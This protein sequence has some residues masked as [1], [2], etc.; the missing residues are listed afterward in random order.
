[1]LNLIKQIYAMKYLPVVS[2][3][4][5]LNE[6][7]WRFHRDL[8]VDFTSLYCTLLYIRPELSSNE[9]GKAFWSKITDS[10]AL[11]PGVLTGVEF[12]S[13]GRN[14]RVSGVGGRGNL[15]HGSADSS[16]EN[17]WADLEGEWHSDILW[18]EL[19]IILNHPLHS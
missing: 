11:Y 8:G 13:G 3:L 5:K 16:C 2:S 18:Y 12:S 15:N 6:F 14:F 9:A 10:V 7:W 1:M 17:Y 19:M 4:L